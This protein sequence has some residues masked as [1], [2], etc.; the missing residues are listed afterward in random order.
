[1]TISTIAHTTTATAVL[2]IRKEDQDQPSTTVT[3][4]H[5]AA[6]IPLLEV[7]DSVVAVVASVAVAVLGVA[8]EPPAEVVVEDVKSAQPDKR[9]EV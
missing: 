6:P 7:Q 8:V 9:R 1:M 5:L 2:T 4:A 3:A